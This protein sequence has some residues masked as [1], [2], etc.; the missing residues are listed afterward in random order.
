MPDKLRAQIGELSVPIATWEEIL[1]EFNDVGHPFFVDELQ[2]ALT[3]YDELR[4]KSKPTGSNAEDWLTGT[5]LMARHAEGE[6]LWVGRNGGLSGKALAKDLRTGKWR[7][8]KYEYRTTEFAGTNWFS[9]EAFAQA[10]AETG[11]KKKREH[12]ARCSAVVGE[13]AAR[14]HHG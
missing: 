2:Q 13:P 1:A 7:K 4:S 11:A 12:L 10:V 8:Q 6:R 9:L 14:S 5:E 3:R